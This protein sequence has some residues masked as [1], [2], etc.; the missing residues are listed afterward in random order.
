MSQW[1]KI[2]PDDPDY[3]RDL[4]SLQVLGEDAIQETES[5]SHA[6]GAGH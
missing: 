6:T 1:P 3:R 4:A 5:R 2:D